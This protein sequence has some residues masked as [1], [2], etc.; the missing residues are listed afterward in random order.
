VSYGVGFNV[1][2]GRQS[3]HKVVEVVAILVLDTKI[4]DDQD[5]SNGTGEVTE[6]ARGGS[7]N[8]PKLGEKR[9]QHVV[10]EFP[11]L[12]ESVYRL[13]RSKEHIGSP[14][15]PVFFGE[16]GETE[17]QK[18]LGGILVSEDFNEGGVGVRRA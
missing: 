18:N 2:A 13:V 1:I 14:C 10:G 8:K 3:M 6:Q 9:D 12:F 16:G 17:T 7:F 5:E 11:G 15:S 4:V